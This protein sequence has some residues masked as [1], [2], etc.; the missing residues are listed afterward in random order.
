MRS[1]V[2]ASI[3]AVMFAEGIPAA[4]FSGPPQRVAQNVGCASA[5]DF[6]GDSDVDVLSTRVIAGTPFGTEVIVYENVSGEIAWSRARGLIRETVPL[7][8]VGTAAIGDR[9]SKPHLLTMAT[10]LDPSARVLM[11]WRPRTDGYDYVGGL[12]VPTE[13]AWSVTV[14]DLTKDGL[15]DVLSLDRDSLVTRVGHSSGWF[16]GPFHSSVPSALW[17]RSPIHRAVGDFD[18]DGVLDVVIIQRETAA[19]GTEKYEAVIMSGDGTGRFTKYAN[20]ILPSM[21]LSVGATDVDDDG[22]DEMITTHGQAIGRDNVLAWRV[23]KSTPFVKVAGADVARLPVL[24]AVLDL[25][26]D[27]RPDLLLRETS[28]LGADGLY[29]VDGTRGGFAAAETYVGAI[30]YGSIACTAAADVSG[31]G[32]PDLL[33]VTDNRGASSLLVF[34]N[35]TPPTFPRRRA[36]RK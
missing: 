24:L 21:P 13:M 18:G 16:A 4:T 5:S 15:A 11:M 31:D 10:P 3:I 9:H 27:G 23:E 32:V 36:A 35:T 6:D 25:S 22:A 7:S 28:P 1:I 29:I 12:S 30:G 19:S 26:R 14:M 20:F 2:H 8:R 34:M 33:V 17:L